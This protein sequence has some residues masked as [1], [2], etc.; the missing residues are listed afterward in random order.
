VLVIFYYFHLPN[1]SRLCRCTFI[2]TLH[3]YQ[4]RLPVKCELHKYTKTLD[5]DCSTFELTVEGSAAWNDV[6]SSWTMYAI[7]S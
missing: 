4:T 1:I 2:Y 6:L 5:A 7:A 3:A